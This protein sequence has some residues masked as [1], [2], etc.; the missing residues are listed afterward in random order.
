MKG[1]DADVVLAKIDATEEKDLA[2]EYGVSGYPTLFWFVD[3]VKTDYK[4]GRTRWVA[5]LHRAELLLAVHVIFR[6]QHLPASVW[7]CSSNCGRA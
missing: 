5:G 2:Q 6:V 3:G 4:G 1:S 7:M